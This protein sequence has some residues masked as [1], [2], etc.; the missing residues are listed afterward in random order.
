MKN[1]IASI[2]SMLAM[3][4]LFVACA[5]VDSLPAEQQQQAQMD[6]QGRSGNL[7]VYAAPRVRES[8]VKFIEYTIKACAGSG[9]DFSHT[10]VV[11]IDSEMTL[12][13]GFKHFEDNPLDHKSSHLFAD[14]FQVLE[15]GCYDVTGI[16]LDADK[17]VIESCST[18]ASNGLQ[19]VASN[20]TE[21]LMIVQCQSP[22]P[23]AVDVVT[24]VNHEPRIT[25]IVFK[26]KTST[27]L[28]DGSKFVC[29]YENHF[30]VEARDSDHDPL[31]FR[32]S[33]TIEGAAAPCEVKQLEN[34][35]NVA[36]E[37]TCFHIKCDESGRI[38]LDVTV[39]DLVRD[40]DKKLIT[41]EDYFDAKGTPKNS[42]AH[43]SFMTYLGGE[44]ACDKPC[45]KK[46]P[47]T[48]QCPK[49]SDD[50]S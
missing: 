34:P 24:V 31:E 32:V 40:A 37:E 47:D 14:H 2:T 10:A 4:T 26:K 42:R 45:E 25:D 3:S 15:A 16:P 12:P 43:M 7:R 1:K 36:V 35:D 22:D 21:A 49:K 8:G 44:E 19:V 29:G 28:E 41:F 20:T 39:F 11:A 23:G 30:C 6:E 13:G 27:G 18:A 48:D 38:D 9:S 33:A 5:D 17:N 50:A 46:C